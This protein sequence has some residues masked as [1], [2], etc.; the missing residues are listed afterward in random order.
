MKILLCR[1]RLLSGLVDFAIELAALLHANMLKTKL[2][3]IDNSQYRF[4]IV[5]STMQSD[6][7]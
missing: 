1:L 3:Q 6:F 2:F 7:V 5:L 4:S